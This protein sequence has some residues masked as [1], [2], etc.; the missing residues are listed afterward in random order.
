M[1]NESSPNNLKRSESDSK[2]TINDPHDLREAVKVS[3]A[4]TKELINFVDG[5]KPLIA[6]LKINNDDL[7]DLSEVVSML[8]LRGLA[9]D[10]SAERLIKLQHRGIE[11]TSEQL[12]VLASTDL[13]VEKAQHVL[14]RRSKNLYRAGTL[15]IIATFLLLVAGSIFIGSQIRQGVPDDVLGV[16]SVVTQA[17]TITQLL[18]NPTHALILRI[19]QAT[20]LSAFVL[21][22]VKY[23]IGLGRS[24]FHEAESLRQR[25]HALRFGRLYV[26]LNSGS[27]E[28]DKLQEAFQWN[29]EAH[30]SYLDMKPEIITETV[31]QRLIDAAAKS[32]T[33]SVK[34]I[35]ET[36]IAIAGK[37]KKEK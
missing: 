23:L 28:L 21:V 11:L 29:K 20:A 10:E 22:G 16:K 12:F 1:S 24:F 17:G 26:Y 9:L 3:L 5:L 34:A 8:P 7:N 31:I 14:S 27:V 30:T 19:F 2:V 36:L 32:P 15:T 37:V 13:F 4:E 33:E 6:K 18:T 35:T 25:R